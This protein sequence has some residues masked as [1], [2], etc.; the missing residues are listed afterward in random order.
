MER[1]PIGLVVV[2]LMATPVLAH[3]PGFP[4][5][6]TTPEQAIEVPDPVK[7]WAFYDSLDEGQVKYYRLTVPAGERLYV[8]TFT[9]RSEGLTPSIVVMSPGENTTDTVPGSVTVPDG[10]GAIVVEGA[11]PNTASYELFNPSANYHT[12][13]F[14]QAVE[15]QETYLIAIYEPDDRTGPVGV[16]IGY[17]EEFSPTEYLGVPFDRPRIHLWEG[18]HPLL[19]FGPYVLTVLAGIGLVRHRW[20]ADWDRKPTRVTLAAGGLLLAATGVNTLL[21]M[22]LALAQ[23]GPTLG[24]L[25]TGVFILIPLLGGSWAVWRALQR[26]C[27]LTLRRRFGLALAGGLALITWA[28]FIV[29]PLVL[30][31][32]AVAPTSLLGDGYPR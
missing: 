28:G 32:L 3:V 1:L 11:R 25:I 4:T 5:D 12:A 18:Q 10:M 27:L 9:P 15:Q 16:T 14:E 20:R 31:G 24:A 19:V 26:D 17:E 29:G 6:N 21:Q 30:L 8:G 23:T 2:L 22:G 13:E 7:S